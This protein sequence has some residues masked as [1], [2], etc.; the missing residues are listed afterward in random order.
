[1]LVVLAVLLYFYCMIHRTSAVAFT[2]A[3]LALS[4]CKTY[5]IPVD[6]FRKQFRNM[7]STTAVAKATPGWSAAFH[8]S[9]DSFL[10]HSD[11]RIHCEDKHHREVILKGGP[12]IEIRF[13]YGPDNKRT[14]VYFDTMFLTDS[15]VTG[16]RSR[17]IPSL[18]STIPLSSITKI[19][20]QDDHKKYIYTDQNGR[21]Q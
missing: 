9:R 21:Y 13:T 7:D 12:S 14:I 19:E 20:V 18:K 11:M 17:I 15:T 8:H 10:I 4:S 3:I 1:M 6:S 2:L 5:T 16:Q